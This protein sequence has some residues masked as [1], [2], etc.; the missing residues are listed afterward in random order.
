MKINLYHQRQKC[1]LGALVSSNIGLCAHADICGGSLERA[2]NDSAWG[3]RERQFSMLSV[4]TF[5]EVLEIR[6]S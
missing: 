3:G 6:P 2:S 1:R 4:I 5:S